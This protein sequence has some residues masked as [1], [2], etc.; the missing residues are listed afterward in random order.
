MSSAILDVKPS[1]L[2][3]AM[4]TAC[5]RAM[6]HGTAAIGHGQPALVRLSLMK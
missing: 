6:S 4:V 5:K 1:G 2:H 3:V